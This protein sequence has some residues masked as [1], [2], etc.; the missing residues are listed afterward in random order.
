MCFCGQAVGLRAAGGTFGGAR[1]PCEFMCLTLK[2][3]QIQP[4]KDIII[5][6]IKNDEFKYV[7]MLGEGPSVVLWPV[8]RVDPAHSQHGYCSELMLNVRMLQTVDISASACPSRRVLPAAG[9]QAA[10]RVQL[11]GAAA[12]RL[13][14]GASSLPLEGENGTQWVLLPPMRF[15]RSEGSHMSS[16]RW[17]CRCGCG[18]WMA[19]SS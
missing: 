9:G 6:Y 11:P 8:C 4:D 15:L 5:E 18:T 13:P 19:P 14:K 7:R 12:E 3:L 16:W 17:C 2:L 1:K 10:G